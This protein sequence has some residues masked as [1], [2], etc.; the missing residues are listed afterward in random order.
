MRYKYLSDSEIL[1]WNKRLDS[2]GYSVYP[3]PNNKLYC[4]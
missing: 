3:M 2:S 1:R 4:I